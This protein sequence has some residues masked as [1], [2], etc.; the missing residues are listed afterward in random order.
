MACLIAGLL[1]RLSL[2]GAMSK[3]ACS[4]WIRRLLL[5]PAIGRVAHASLRNT[6][7]GKPSKRQSRFL[8]ESLADER[9]WTEAGR[10]LLK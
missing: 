1:C 6:R 8:N 7:L 10:G 2:A 5:Q 4:F 9:V 3:I